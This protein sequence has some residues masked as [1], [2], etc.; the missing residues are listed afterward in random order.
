MRARQYG[1]IA[2]IRMKIIKPNNLIEFIEADLKLQGQSGY[3]NR[4]GIEKLIKNYKE[5]K[6]I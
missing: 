1:F 4:A 5:I 3:L 6:N 2:R